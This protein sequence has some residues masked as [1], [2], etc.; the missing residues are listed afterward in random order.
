MKKNVRNLLITVII[1][2]VLLVVALVAYNGLKDNAGSSVE[3]I[4]T[5]KESAVSAVVPPATEVKPVAEKASMDNATVPATPAATTD[6]VQTADKTAVSDATA[7]TE[8][9]EQSANNQEAPKMPDIPLTKLD[10]TKTSF[11][12]V[13]QGKPVIIN[14]FA[15]WCPPCKQELP[16]FLKAYEKYKDQ[17]E[18]IFIDSLDGSR[19]T[20]STIKAFVKDFPF[21]GPVYFDDGA[22]AYLFQT[23]SLPTTVIFSSDGT[24]L[25]GHLGMISK[26][27]LQKDIETLLP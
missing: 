3:Y 7:T 11:D 25:G 26:E 17:I 1:F 22:F 20:E 18:F 12:T 4:P 23:S 10:G 19:E 6:S 9:A 16:D 5:I 2:I 15:S 13:R 14:Y 8:T 21:T 27:V 24:V